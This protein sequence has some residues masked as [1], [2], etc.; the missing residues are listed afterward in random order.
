MCVCVCGCVRACVRACVC[1]HAY[2]R[3]CVCVPVD[4]DDRT[5]TRH[6]DPLRVKTQTKNQNAPSPAAIC[7]SALGV[8]PV[9]ATP[10]RTGRAEAELVTTEHLWEAK[11][12]KHLDRIRALRGKHLDSIRA[13]RGKHSSQIDRAARPDMRAARSA[14]A[15]GALNDRALKGTGRG[16]AMARPDTVLRGRQRGTQKRL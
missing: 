11:Q 2:V 8:Q 10:Q 12:L 7:P 9:C 13:L 16:T 5:S 3:M 15:C 1:A 14:I 4:I 6:S